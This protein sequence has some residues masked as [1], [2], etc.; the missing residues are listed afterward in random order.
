MTTEERAALDAVMN[1]LDSYAKRSV[2]GCMY[3]MATSKPILLLGTNENEVFRSSGDVRAAFAKDFDN[4][5]DIR[6]GK[7]RNVY[8]E[9]VSTLASVIVER[10]VAY[11]SGG[12]EVETL[13]RY[14]LTLTKEGGQWKVCAG[15]ASVPFSAGTY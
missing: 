5:T 2:E 4:M 10:T 1:F 8:V 7:D 11:R 14:A 3:A 12:K 6:W 13:F 9:V 15:M